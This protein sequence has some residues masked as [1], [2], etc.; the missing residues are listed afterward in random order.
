MYEAEL[1]PNGVLGPDARLA[2]LHAK[3]LTHCG[4]RS[5]GVGACL[6][7][8][9]E[10]CK[11]KKVFTFKFTA[12]MQP[13]QLELELQGVNLNFASCENLTRSVLDVVVPE[14]GP[15]D[16]YVSFLFII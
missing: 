9:S 10:L 2:G 6:V 11:N 12:P 1:S 3:L 5:V 14:D 15:D 13:Q 7:G 8:G 4:A 16:W